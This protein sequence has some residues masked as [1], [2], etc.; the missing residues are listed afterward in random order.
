MVKLYGKSNK[1]IIERLGQLLL[2]VGKR[3]MKLEKAHDGN[4]LLVILDSSYVG[5][6]FI[7]IL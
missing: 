5:T 6:Y 7:T 1:R 3:G 4:G 2:M